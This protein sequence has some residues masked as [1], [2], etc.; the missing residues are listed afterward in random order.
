MEFR[1]IAQKL[2]VE[3][4]PAELDKLYKE[5]DTPAC[6]FSLMERLQTE[7]DLF[8]DYYDK[9][10]EAAQQINSD[11]ARSAWVRTTVSFAKD[12]DVETACTVPAPATDGTAAGDFLPLFTLLP[13]IPKAIA[14]Y[15]KRGFSYDEIL[16]IMK[17]FRLSFGIVEEQTGSSGVENIYYGWLTIFAKAQIFC[18][19]GLQF[20]FFKLPKGVLWLRNR[21]TGEVVPVMLEGT[22]HASGIQRLGSL[23]YA[24]AEGAFTPAFSEDEKNYYGHGVHDCIVSA[25]Q[26]TFSKD[27]WEG[28]GRPRGFCMNIH[29][30]RGSDISTETVMT[31]CK[32]ARQIVR[33][34]YPELPDYCLVMGISWLLNPKLREIQGERAKTVQFMECFHKYPKLDTH[35]DSVF[36]FVFGKKYENYAGLPENTSLQRKLKKLYLDGGCL[37]GYSGAI[38]IEEK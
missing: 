20:E 24:D 8:G 15:K 25:T 19:M 36:S 1:Q 38:Y 12:A 34:R 30:P 6:D 28:I 21:T 4:Y 14:E 35:A 7:Y 5:N 18:L 23:G 16:D 13:Q 11:P 27:V 31:A 3:Q 26:E 17:D 32:Q 29:V 2:G 22:F 10:R 33:T 9:V 37:H